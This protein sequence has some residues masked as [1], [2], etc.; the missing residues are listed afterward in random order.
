MKH[1]ISMTVLTDWSRPTSMSVFIW[2]NPLFPATLKKTATHTSPFW[3]NLMN[4]LSSWVLPIKWCLVLQQFSKRKITCSK[5]G[6]LLIFNDWFVKSCLILFLSKSA[7]VKQRDLKIYLGMSWWVKCR[8]FLFGRKCLF[9]CIAEVILEIF[10][11]NVLI[12]GKRCNAHILKILHFA[13]KYC[14]K[15]QGWYIQILS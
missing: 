8:W 11:K 14:F 2:P 3:S 4:F 7:I 6:H 13:K 15:K 9:M 12:L 5:L 10:I 1:H